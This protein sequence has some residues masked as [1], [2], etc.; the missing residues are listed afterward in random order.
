MNGSEQKASVVPGVSLAAVDAI[1]DT[2]LR[3]VV[4]SIV[5]GLN[6]RNGHAGSGDERFVTAREL[7]LV[8][9][10]TGLGV[11][12]GTGGSLSSPS[13]VNIPDIARIINDLQA[14]IMES[15]LFK[16][17]GQRVELIDGNITKE[18]TDRIKAVTDAARDLTGKIE[19]AAKDAA[20]NLLAE[21]QARGTA[22]DN[23]S[24]VLNDS[25]GA[26][27]QTVST[28][29]AKTDDN[30][31]AIQTETKART[32]AISAEAQQRTTLA[33]RVGETESSITSINRTTQDLASQTDA[34]RTRAGNSES[35]ITT[36]N[37]TTAQQAQ[38]ITSLTTRTDTAE[39]SIVTLNKTTADQA[40][41]ATQL[42]NRVG[43]AET[44][45]GT[46]QTASSG[47][48]SSIDSLSTSLGDTNAAVTGERDTRVNSDN[49]L[50]NAVNTLWATVGNGSALVQGGSSITA[51]AGGAAATAWNQVQAA[52]R[53]SAGNLISSA[54]IRQETSAVA[55]RQGQVESKWVVNVDSGGLASGYR[56]A[57]FGIY[58]SGTYDSPTYAFGVRAD[59]FWIA[60]PGEVAT[61]NPSAAK[62]PFIVKT[63]NWVDS[64]GVVQ[65][66]GVYLNE[67]FAT[68]AKIGV[69]QI[70][71]AHIGE[72]QI[73]AA[74]IGYAEINGA[75]IGTLTVDTFH[76][77]DRAITTIVT[78]EGSG[79]GGPRSNPS[80]RITATIT[81][82][83]TGGPLLVGCT[84]SGGMNW[85]YNSENASMIYSAY[86]MIT[87]ERD[88]LMR[89]FMSSSQAVGYMQ[90][91]EMRSSLSSGAYMETLPAG[92]YTF[93]FTGQAYIGYC[94]VSAFVMEAKR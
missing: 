51:G 63:A 26:L 76:L 2:N 21:A 29:S 12:G 60:S 58:G 92:T 87:I 25:L 11:G 50:A 39:S 47:H 15:P 17:L 88:G 72:A 62:I 94:L 69:A 24:K 7:G 53:D 75:H 71:S 1:K 74:N 3:Q 37:E 45:I 43:Q 20:D 64:Q 80:N 73:K 67:L 5:D 59:T 49:A 28:V 57:G 56:Q 91:N 35:A 70:Q 82:T 40:Q 32:D 18:I 19:A 8:K 34:L 42:T 86:P 22:I 44:T 31:S 52:L 4:R 41:A 16:L 36:L 13:K 38:S 46:L 66:P 84:F 65:P 81:I 90:G 23:A 78:A 48:A 61:A 54:A 33:A 30:V 14:Q 93:T 85:T 77:K 9:G 68:S 79:D 55:S 89:Q 6:V 10:R 83:T 27:A